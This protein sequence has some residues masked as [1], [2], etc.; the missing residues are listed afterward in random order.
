MTN[1]CSDENSLAAMPALTRDI[2]VPRWPA[3]TAP[4]MMS[5]TIGEAPVLK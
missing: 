2:A 5:S 4:T 3:L 1:A